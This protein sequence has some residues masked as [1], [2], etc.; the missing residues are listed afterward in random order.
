MKGTIAEFTDTSITFLEEG[1]EELQVL[2]LAAHIKPEYVRKGRASLTVKDN[3]VTFVTMESRQKETDKGTDKKTES[4]DSHIVNISGK[5]FM[6]Y[7]GLLAKAH[8]KGK[9]SMIITESWVSEDMKRAWCKV[10]LTAQNQN[11]K[12]VGDWVFD[13]FG[14]STPENTGEMTKTHPVE[15]AHTRAKGRALRDYLNI[16]QV[17]A[18]ELKDG[19]K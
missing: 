3:E 8:A 1:V 9:F 17:M 19:S 6:T 18:E 13:G 16:G 14:S 7:G 5:D 4:K 12:E 15:M 10:R 2:E 11:K